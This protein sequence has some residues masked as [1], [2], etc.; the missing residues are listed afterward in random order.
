MESFTLDGTKKE[1]EINLDPEKGLIEIKGRSIPEN[2]VGFYE[3]VFKWLENYS[4]N[5]QPVTTINIDLE[6]FNTTSAKSLFNLF[7]SLE[8]LPSE[9]ILN[10]MYE[11]GDDDIMFAG[12]DYKAMLKLKEINIIEVPYKKPA[13]Q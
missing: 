7:K 9:V 1:P 2:P 13:G 10:W 11:E 6:Y 8:G 5:P 3:P 4:A 12:E